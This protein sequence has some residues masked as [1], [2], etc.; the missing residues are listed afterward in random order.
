MS[1]DTPPTT[2]ADTDSGDDPDAY[3]VFRQVA[4][5]AEQND[6]T[7]GPGRAAWVITE[8][9]DRTPGQ[10]VFMGFMGRYLAG[11]YRCDGCGDDDQDHPGTALVLPSDDAP[12]G[13]AAGAMAA[14]FCPTCALRL[15]RE[16]LR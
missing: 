2:D 7:P 10:A 9:D 5:E 16:S 3:Q 6:I 4:Q 8:W 15:L 14:P 13:G 11:S 1:T 12:K